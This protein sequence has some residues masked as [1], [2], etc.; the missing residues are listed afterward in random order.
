MTAPTGS[1]NR[2]RMWLRLSVCTAR[3]LS[4][5]ATRNEQAAWNTFVD[6][7]DLH[8]QLGHEYNELSKD[9]PWQM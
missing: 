8:R 4:A 9:R 6:V 5:L 3:L 7:E 1:V 2:I